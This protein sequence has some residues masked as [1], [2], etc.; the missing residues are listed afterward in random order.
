[1]A[2][3][4]ALAAVTLA[5]C[6]QFFLQQQRQLRRRTSPTRSLESLAVVRSLAD[7]VHVPLQRAR[8]KDGMPDVVIDAVVKVRA[9]R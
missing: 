7:S 8:G 6:G 2:G 1:M 3:L 9:A 5:F 4:A